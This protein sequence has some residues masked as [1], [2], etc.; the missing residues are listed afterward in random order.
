MR[1]RTSQVRQSQLTTPAVASEGRRTALR[2]YV[3]D[4]AERT[5]GS[6]RDGLSTIKEKSVQ[7]E[8]LGNGLGPALHCSEIG[9]VY[10][11]VLIS[12]SQARYW[13]LNYCARGS[14]PRVAGRVV[15]RERGLG[16]PVGV[17]CGVVVRVQGRVRPGCGVADGGPVGGQLAPRS[18]FCNGLRLGADVAGPVT[19][20]PLFRLRPRDARAAGAP[21]LPGAAVVFRARVGA[22]TP[23][24]YKPSPRLVLTRRPARSLRRP[25]FPSFGPSPMAIDVVRQLPVRAHHVSL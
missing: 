13:T 24:A 18:R 14:C 17:A 10:G 2:N 23:T 15:W 12:W 9:R 5:T 8:G 1:F 3:P 16:R 4:G 21:P 11:S 20:W 19:G 22:P 7:V 6:A 25:A